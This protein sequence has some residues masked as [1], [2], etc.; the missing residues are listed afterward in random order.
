MLL[1]C[2]GIRLLTFDFIMRYFVLALL[3]G[4]IV[5]VAG[6]SSPNTPPTPPA[7]ISLST[8]QPGLVDLEPGGVA[9]RAIGDTAVNF[10]LVSHVL[11]RNDSNVALHLLAK[12]A[13][14]GDTTAHQVQAL[15]PN[16]SGPQ[17]IDSG[18][19]D[20]GI[21]PPGSSEAIDSI[22]IV[23]LDSILPG[24]QVDYSIQF[25]VQNGPVLALDYL[26]WNAPI[27][28]YTNYNLSVPFS[29]RYRG[30]IYTT[31]SSPTP[32]GVIDAPDSTD[33]VG[34]SVFMP[35]PAYPNPATVTTSL[36]FTI[37]NSLDS[38][39]GDLYIT[40]HH[41]LKTF[42]N[43][44]IKGTGNHEVSLNLSGIS[45]GL[46]QVHWTAF[47]NGAVFTSHGNIMVPLP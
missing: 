10:D 3:T 2:S 31:E 9:I 21:I 40:P 15:V 30:I 20:L 36:G 5:V 11:I 26:T 16:E 44:P 22:P 27:S 35:S 34:D 29:S 7:P 46:Y 4:L 24:S 32:I 25:Q 42:I 45:S 12:W 14:T 8:S 1:G 43:G 39:R 38:L 37:P 17:I 18:T 23:T 19:V 41:I 13:L 28:S 47:K 6:C 33:W